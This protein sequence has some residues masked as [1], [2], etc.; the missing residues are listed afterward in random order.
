LRHEF[1]QEPAAKG[2]ATTAT[3]ARMAPVT[4]FYSGRGVGLG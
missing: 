4:I 1:Q 2:R 3:V